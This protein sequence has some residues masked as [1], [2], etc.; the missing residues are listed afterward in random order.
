MRLFG[1]YRR[2]IHADTP[3]LNARWAAHVAAALQQPPPPS[4]SLPAS[5]SSSSL[6]GTA[7]GGSALGGALHS[8]RMHRESSS[9]R[10]LSALDASGHGGPALGRGSTHNGAFGG[11]AGGGGLNPAD[12]VIKA[13][14]FVF[15]H[16]AFVLS[17]R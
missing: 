11:G 2:F 13:A 15:E 5:A 10:P 4:S 16:T 8:P 1:G 17:H 9:G 3:Q 14:G 7:S 6:V 12:H